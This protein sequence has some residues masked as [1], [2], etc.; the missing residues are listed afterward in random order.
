MSF[1]DGVPAYRGVTNDASWSDATALQFTGDA[2]VSVYNQQFAPVVED[3]SKFLTL[4]FTDSTIAAPYAHGYIDVEYISPAYAYNWAN[5][6]NAMLRVSAPLSMTSPNGVD[7]YS[8]ISFTWPSLTDKQLVLG[9]TA[10]TLATLPPG[11]DAK[12]FLKTGSVGVSPSWVQVAWGDL[13]GVPAWLNASYAQYGVTYAA[14]SSSMA[15]T[16]PGSSGHFLR[17]GGGGGAPSFQQVDTANLSGITWGSGTYKVAYTPDALGK[18]F[19]FSNSVAAGKYLGYNAGVPGFVTIPYSDIS[20]TPTIPSF[21][22]SIA[23]GGTGLTATPTDGQ[24][25]IGK[26]STNAYVNTTLTGTANRVTVTNGS[27]TVTLS[28]PQDIGTSSAPSFAQ[29]NVA[30][31]DSKQ[32]FVYVAAHYHTATSEAFKA[33]YV[34]GYV[35]GVPS[36][37]GSTI[38]IFRSDIKSNAGSGS[39]TVSRFAHFNCYAFIAFETVTNYYGVWVQAPGFGSGGSITNGWG[40]YFARP[41][42]GTVNIG[43]YA[44]NLSVGSA[45][46]STNPPANGM[47]VQGAIKND[48]LTASSLVATDGSK[49]LSS[50][51]SGLS[52]TFT[53][54]TLSGLTASSL[55]A[56]DGSKQLT[57]TTS[58]LTPTFTGVTFGDSTLSKY[59]VVTGATATLTYSGGTTT[60]TY[61]YVITG[62]KATVRITGTTVTT[63]GGAAATMSFV[64][65]SEINAAAASG[66][67]CRAAWGGHNV[68]GE[69]QYAAIGT[70]WTLYRWNGTD[71]T[72]YP[73]STAGCGINDSCFSFTLN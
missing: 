24:L 22:L 20:G 2:I 7:T 33:V 31:S 8:T 6:V 63:G 48:N 67:P 64:L 28:G 61:D 58:G 50:T 17:S 72:T 38:D 59:K 52:P 5:L 34:D 42:G 21:P 54:L 35:A 26:T 23:D 46:A 66:A 15:T 44:E 10:A 36:S 11:S 71:M 14:T 62:K 56:T 25:L 18:I 53:A 1:F 65:A 45:N 19:A 47:V 39:C 70:T 51:T 68:P 29:L 13:T 16:P 55:V 49:Q 4:Q 40:G 9:D 3:D 30:A 27:G 43:V 41:G 32:P 12:Q 73:A 37:T 57:S 69:L 60:L